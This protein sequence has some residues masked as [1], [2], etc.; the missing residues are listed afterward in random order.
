ML[1]PLLKMALP[2][3]ACICK[4]KEEEQQKLFTW[5]QQYGL[6]FW[7]RIQHRSLPNQ[8]LFW[9]SLK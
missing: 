4:I 9:K 3:Q 5:S 1:E 6:Q 8:C 7:I 2:C